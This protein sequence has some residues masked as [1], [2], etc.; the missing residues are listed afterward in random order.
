M[1]C[2]GFPFVSW[3]WITDSNKSDLIGLAS[4]LGETTLGKRF[5]FHLKS[6]RCVN[7]H[8]RKLPFKQSD[9]KHL[10]HSAANSILCF[11]RR[12]F[13]RFCNTSWVLCFD[14]SKECWYTREKL[15]SHPIVSLIITRLWIF[16]LHFPFHHN[17]P[18]F[19]FFPY[20]SYILIKSHLNSIWK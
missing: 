13:F 10:I 6:F 18:H 16:S 17:F 1:L 4:H 7:I 3:R 8:L 12:S 11:C 5:F 15:Y 2:L 9:L 20:I 14:I 19:W